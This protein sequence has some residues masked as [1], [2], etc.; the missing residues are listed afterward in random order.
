MGVRHFNKALA[1]KIYFDLEGAKQTLASKTS[2]ST[3]GRAF[4]L[5]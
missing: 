5:L 1:K 2:P 4:H 3:K